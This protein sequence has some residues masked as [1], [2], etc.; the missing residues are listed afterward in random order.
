MS[1]A[2]RLYDKWK[3]KRLQLSADRRKSDEASAETRTG[4]HAV[5][6]TFEVLIRLFE[7]A[8]IRI[9]PTLT[10]TTVVTIGR[11]VLIESFIPVSLISSATEMAPRMNR[12]TSLFELIV[13][14]VN[15]DNFAA[16]SANLPHQILAVTAEAQ[17]ERL[18]EMNDP[19]RIG[20]KSEGTEIVMCY[21]HD[22]HCLGSVYN[23]G[24]C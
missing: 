12:L 9:V 4:D 10:D 15:R 24:R 13:L 16:H 7:F 2:Y 14:A 20:L 19:A 17:L 23:V 3:S 6:V 8:D 22:E 11:K 21:F 18:D 1:A 5:S